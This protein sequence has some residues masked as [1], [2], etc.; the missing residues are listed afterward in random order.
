MSSTDVPIVA[1]GDRLVLKLP[2]AEEGDKTKVKAV[3]LKVKETH[4]VKHGSKYKYTLQL[5]NESKDLLETRLHE[6][7]WKPAKKSSKRGL[8]DDEAAP[9]PLSQ[10]VKEE[11]VVS[12]ASKKH[13]TDVTIETEVNQM[14]EVV[15]RP[16]KKHRAKIAF[17]LEA[18][19]YILAPMVGA[20]ELAFRLL[21]RKYGTSLA[22][23][24]MINSDKFAVDEAYRREEYQTTS[25]DRPVVAHFSAN[26]PQAFLAAAKHVEDHCDAIDLNLGC[27][28]RV[29]FSGHFGSFLLDEADRPLVLSLVRIIAEN[30]KVPIFVKIRLLDTIEDTIKLCQQLVEA[31]ASLITIHG[32]YRVNLAGRTGP[33]ARDGP[34]HLDQ[35]KTIREVITT[36][37]IISNGNVRTWDDVVNN[38]AFT[39]TAGIMSAEGILDNPAIFNRGNAVDQLQLGLEYLDLVRKHPVKLKSVVFHIR[40][41]CKDILTKYQMLEDCVQATSVEEVMKI[42]D[43]ISEFERTGSFKFDPLKAKREKEALERR[44]REEGKRKEFEAR[45]IRKAKREGKDLNYYLMQ[46]SMIPTSEIIEGLK[47]MKREEAFEVW[48]QNHGQHCWAFHLEAGGCP[49]DRKCAFLHADAKVAQGE[50]YG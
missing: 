13:K 17:P 6:I 7:E 45:M 42:M 37:P 48:K 47:S 10:S 1:V 15:P 39:N 29:A 40:R 18:L 21:C 28:Q 44:K 14:I 2:S 46:G 8:L 43:N 49:R 41:M 27:P 30:C 5:E 33:G 11:E 25:Q 24:P 22:Y 38:M 4:K 35:I 26:N 34:A 16:I 23:T 31:G 20:S 32:R 36:I 50:S 19:K 9:R 12:K 3:V